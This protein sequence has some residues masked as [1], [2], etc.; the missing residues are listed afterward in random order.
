VKILVS[1][2]SGHPF[3]VQLAR[4]LSALG[5]EVVH[6]YFAGFQT[7]KG[8]L[9]LRKDDPDGFSIHPV[10]LEERF[11]KQS[12]L[13]RRTQEINVGK[14]IGQIIEKYRPDVVLSSNAPLDAQQCILRA[15]R[16]TGSRFAF[17]LQD[18]YSEAI[19]GILQKRF[20]LVGHQIGLYYQRKEVKLLQRS[21][22]IVAISDDFTKFL[23]D[24]HISTRIVVVENWVPL[25]AFLPPEKSARRP[26]AAFR[27]VYAGT[28]GYKHDPRMLLLLAKETDAEVHVY[29]EGP[30]ADYLR[31]H[32]ALLPNGKL[33]VADWV[34]F[35]DLGR[36]LANADVLIALIDADASRYSVPSKVLSYLCAGRA[37]L[38]SIPDDNQSAR[39]VLRE[40]AGL[41]TPPGQDREFVEKARWLMANPEA[42]A[43]MGAN[44]RA[45]AERTFQIERIAEKFEVA[46]L[47]EMSSPP[48]QNRRLLSRH[49]S[50]PASTAGLVAESAPGGVANP[51]ATSSDP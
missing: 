27:F 42:C 40:K 41:V 20:G 5:H 31:Q 10:T 3:Q 22:L 37:V 24:H 50:A 43:R 48:P 35:E 11:D 1:D 44:G 21:N 51:R 25:S 9:Q 14:R 34:P 18:I 46:F 36:T 19:K 17:W 39:I 16:R 12:F 15:S 47:Q 49:A 29:S 28:L 13:K 26:E 7:P 23:H 38:L 32:A 4:Q 2:Y 8:D 6:V 45:Y 30:G 33:V